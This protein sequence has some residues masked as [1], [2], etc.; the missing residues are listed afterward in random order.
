M[1]G[2]IATGNYAI[3]K[4]SENA[5]AT[6]KVIAK[7][8]GETFNE[9]YIA[10]VLGDVNATIELTNSQIDH[11]FFTGSSEVG[12]KIMATASKQ[13]IPVTLE[14]GGKSPVVID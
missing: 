12:K 1:I 6:S 8:I 11:I 5:L 3:I 9:E 4:P 13:L 14:L 2:A 7:I 10:C